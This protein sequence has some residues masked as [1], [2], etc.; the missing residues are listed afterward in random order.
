MTVAVCV[1]CGAIKHGAFTPCAECGFDPDTELD[2]AYSLALTDHYFSRDVLDQIS[3]SIRSGRPRPSLPPDQED[4]FREA[5][6]PFLKVKERRRM[7]AARRTELPS[8]Q[9]NL[10]END[11][12]AAGGSLADGD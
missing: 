11:P 2:A 9:E 3:S 1:Q 6:R 7:K 10:Q 4:R 12:P 5:A 8:G